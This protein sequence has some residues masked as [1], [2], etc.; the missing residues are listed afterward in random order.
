VIAFDELYLGGSGNPRTITIADLLAARFY[1]QPQIEDA[2]KAAGLQPAT[3]HL[4]YTAVFLWREVVPDAARKHKLDALIGHL[5]KIDPAFGAELERRLRP[6]LDPGTWYP[7]HNPYYCCF[8]GPGAATAMIDRGGLRSGLADLANDQCRVLVI[9]G[10]RRSGKTHS[11]RLI[12]HLRQTGKLAGHK[13]IRVSTH[14]WGANTKVTSEMVA[15]EIADLLD[16]DIK[17]TGSGELSQ[18]RTRKILTSLTAKFPIDGVLR[19]IVL[20]GLDREEAIDAEDAQDVALPLITK[21]VDGELPDT[22]LVITGFD[23]LWLRDRRAVQVETIPPISQD[24]VRAF[25]ADAAI[26]LGRE[27]GPA[28]LNAYV[29]EV[30]STADGAEAGQASLVAAGTGL[31]DV[32]GAVV[33]LVKREWGP[34]GQH[35]S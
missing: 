14:S 18:A 10:A 23:P 27:V 3:Y 19:W 13:C 29:K 4:N 7:C 34:G 21:V 2:L 16:L 1:S 26:H 17:M 11:W 25:L 5:V 22:R 9:S 33:R 28:D 32:E 8:F 24:L 35:A 12:E 31:A 20:D 6:L 30:L 15:Q